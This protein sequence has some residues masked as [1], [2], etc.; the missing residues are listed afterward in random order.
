MRAAATRQQTGQWAEAIVHE[1][2]CEQGLRSVERNFRCKTGE[3]DLIMWHGLYLVFV[4]VRYR[5]SQRYGGAIAS[6]N[7]RK[8]AKLLQTAQYYLLKHP[9][10]QNALC[11]FD[12]VLVSGSVDAPQ[13][14]WLQNAFTA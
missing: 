12:T 4:E 14:E 3:I 2:L 6:I 11:R 1:Y 13:I 10:L 5:A 7:A 9:R 8:Q